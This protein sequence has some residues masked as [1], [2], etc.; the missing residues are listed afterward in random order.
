L[1]SGR[2]RILP[3]LLLLVGSIDWTAVA[4]IATLALAVVTAISVAIGW[5]A[6][7]KAQDEVDLSRREVEEA[8]RPLVVPVIELDQSYRVANIGLIPVA[9][10]VQ[11]GGPFGHLRKLIIP[12][13]NIGS[14]PALDVTVGVIGRNDAG[15]YSHAWGPECF[16]GVLA[17]GVQEVKPVDISV[18]PLSDVPSFDIA[19]TYSDLAGK[20]WRTSAKYRARQDPS[21]YIEPSIEVAIAT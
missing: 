8:H 20:T 12:V 11:Q 15:E 6:L 7:R 21:R 5:S 4:A 17:I 14:G 16:G 9:P 1:P 10:T 19:V 3:Y 2:T 18:P 13:R